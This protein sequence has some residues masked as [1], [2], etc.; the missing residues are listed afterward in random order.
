MRRAD[1]HHHLVIAPVH[2]AQVAFVAGAFHQADVG[3][4]LQ[5]RLQ[6]FAG[7]ADA[8]VQR[9]GSAA[10][11]TETRQQ[12]RQDIAADG[13]AGRDAQLHA[14]LRGKALQLVRL[15]Q[16]RQRAREELA[17]GLVDAEAACDAIEQRAVQRTFQFCQRSA[18]GRLRHRQRVRGCHGAAM[19]GD[20][21]EDRQLAQREA[22]GALLGAVF[23]TVFHI[24]RIDNA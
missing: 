15:V 20:G 23:W 14:G 13:V 24:E 1:H 12:R 22:Q 5:Q 21:D 7:V 2:A 8:Q 6:H 9:A 10:R 18:D 16:Q 17:A 3:F 4:E 11:M 19:L